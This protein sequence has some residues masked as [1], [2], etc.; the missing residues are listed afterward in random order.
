LKKVEAGL[1]RD[2]FMTAEDGQGLGPDRRNRERRAVPI[3]A[4]ANEGCHTGFGSLARAGTV[5]DCPCDC[6]P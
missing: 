4:S 2:N 1:E 5:L 6:L 3:A